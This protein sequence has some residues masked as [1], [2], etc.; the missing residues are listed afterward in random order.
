MSKQRQKGKI[1]REQGKDNSL[2]EKVLTENFPKIVN[3][4]KKHTHIFKRLK[5]I[6]KEI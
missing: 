5:K 6:I 4:K 2:N 1:Q 3:E